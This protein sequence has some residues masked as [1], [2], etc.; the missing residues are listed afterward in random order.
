M[1]SLYRPTE[2]PGPSPDSLALTVPSLPI[3]KPDEFFCQMAWPGFCLGR[4]GQ[5]GAADSL[6]PWQGY[7][8]GEWQLG[9]RAKD[10]WWSACPGYHGGPKT[11]AGR[12]DQKGIG[13]GTRLLGL[14]LRDALQRDSRLRNLGK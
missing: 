3:N 4:S 5:E 14:C 1:D 8:A 11:R 6:G 9:R 13:Q 2:Q 12:V 7:P 10:S